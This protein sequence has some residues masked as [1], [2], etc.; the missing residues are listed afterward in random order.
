MAVPYNFFV[1]SRCQ[2]V[3]LE[4]IQSHIL[5]QAPFLYS[6]Y[7]Y[8]HRHHFYTHTCARTHARMHVRS[9]SFLSGCVCYY[10]VASISSVEIYVLA[11]A[12]KYA[13]R[14]VKLFSLVLSLIL[15]FFFFCFL[16]FFP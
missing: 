7:Y 10:W 6:Y 16:S 15:R 9:L 13:G 2:D 4:Y 11:D 8:Y 5:F 12:T 1:C 3:K 14:F